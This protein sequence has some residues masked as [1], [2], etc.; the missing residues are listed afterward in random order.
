MEGYKLAWGIWDFGHRITSRD[1]G[2]PEVH[3][4][5]D[6]I[7]KVLQDIKKEF[8][9]IGYELW[10]HKIIKVD[11]HLCECGKYSE[12]GARCWYCGNEE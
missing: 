11:I 10:F 2:R 1:T 9:L 3:E 12:T 4:S 5:L 7:N 6:K 8:A